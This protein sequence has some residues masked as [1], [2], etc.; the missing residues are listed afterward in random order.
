MF[1][2]SSRRSA[3]G[4][5]APTQKTAAAADQMVE[6][7][8]MPITAYRQM[9]EE[10]P[11]AVITCNLADFTINYVNRST[12]ENLRTIE[13]LLPCRADEIVGQCIDIFH[14]NPAHH[15]RLLS[16]PGNLP[17][18]ANIKLGDQTL[19]LEI[20][21]VT[22]ANGE[23][24]GPML[25]WN[26][27]TEQIRMANAVNEVAEIVAAASTELESTASAMSATAD[28]TS[29]QATLVASA[30]EEASSNVQT[31]ASATG[32][33][34]NSIQ[35][36]SRQVKEAHRIAGHAVEEA[37]RTN[38]TVDS[39][40]QDAQKIGDVVELIKDIADQTNL[41]A[42][43][44]T[45]EAARA[46][47]AGKGF[48]VVASEV[49][50]LASQTAKATEDI[51]GQIGS[52]QTA[53]DGAVSAIQEISSTIEQISQTA[54]TIAG[55]VEQ[56][57]AATQEIARNVQEAASGTGEVS[58]T[59]TGVQ[60]AANETGSSAGEVLEAARDL[61]N[62]S[63]KLRGEIDDFLVDLGAKE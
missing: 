25:C 3:G 45:I 48:A 53:T 20:I 42:L 38:A 37:N 46:G 15:R 41:L 24:L 14:K 9:V 40:A 11:I 1:S 23:Y 33:L 52:M 26:L 63:N 62:H 27:V 57:L 8:S 55:A 2:R 58:Q 16:D 43:N 60:T 34:T 39:L 6:A 36:I 18:R 7:D 22:G 50:N 5:Q 47:D 56:Q 17:H 30:S 54:T 44:A 59:I 4:D 61:Q 12:I 19:N 28:Q 13:H 49:K 21:A 29:K 10:M 32:Q 31:V 35:E 51:A